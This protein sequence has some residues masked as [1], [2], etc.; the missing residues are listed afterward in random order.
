MRTQSNVESV[1]RPTP[2]AIETLP[3]TV[4]FRADTL[5]AA[6]ALA[7]ESLGAPVRVVAANRIRRGGIGG[8][9]ASDLGVEVSV[10]LD[11]ETIEQALERLVAETAVDE[12]THWLEHRAADV[13]RRTPAAHHEPQQPDPVRRGDRAGSAG[14]QR[15]R[16]A[17]ARRLGRAH[18]AARRGAVDGPSRADHRRARLPDPPH[19]S[20]ARLA[21]GSRG[22]A[23]APYGGAAHAAAATGRHRPRRVDQRVGLAGPGD[24]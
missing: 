10:T 1:A 3:E 13:P 18:R 9:F 12:R 17:Q 22:R 15:A 21:A 4:S 6:V 20:R 19:R 16:H 14:A 23:A 24:R 8:F 5:D 2:A 11:D 7:E